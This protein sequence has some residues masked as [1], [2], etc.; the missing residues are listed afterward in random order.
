MALFCFY[1]GVHILTITRFAMVT[2]ADVSLIENVI[3]LTQDQMLWSFRIH[4]KTF[5]AQSKPKS[6][7]CLI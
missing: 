7:F 4:V 5:E 3:R 1:S 2:D 6:T